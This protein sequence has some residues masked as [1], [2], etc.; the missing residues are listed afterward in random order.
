LIISVY[1]NTL[2]IKVQIKQLLKLAIIEVVKFNK[3]LKKDLNL[4]SMIER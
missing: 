4:Y 1:M 2:I 3:Q